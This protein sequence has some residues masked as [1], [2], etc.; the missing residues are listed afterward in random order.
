MTS[1]PKEFQKHYNVFGSVMSIP[2]VVPAADAR[3]CPYTCVVDKVTDEEITYVLRQ[4][5]LPHG[6]SYVKTTF[7]VGKHRKFLD[8]LDRFNAY[9]AW[10]K[11]TKGRMW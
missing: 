10:V 6:G 8:D 7:E 3:A 5:C 9:S 11:N 2:N 4:T 1:Y